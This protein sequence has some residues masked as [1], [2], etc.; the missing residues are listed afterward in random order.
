[1]QSPFTRLKRYRTDKNDQRENHATECLAACLHFSLELREI[2][3]KFLFD[4]MGVQ[5]PPAASLKV[6][7]QQFA[8]Q[9]GIPD[10]VLTDEGRFRIVVEIK[11]GAQLFQDQARKYGRW[12]SEDTEVKQYLFSLEK[13]PRQAFEIAKVSNVPGARRTWHQLYDAFRD[14]ERRLAG[15]TE[16]NL[17]AALCSYLQDEGIVST[18]KPSQILDLGPAVQAKEALSHCFSRVA[19]RLKE[20]EPTFMAEPKTPS[21]QWPR[22]EIGL[23]AW[24]QKFGEGYQGRVW[25]FYEVE[26]V[27]QSKVSRFYFCFFLWNDKF[28][29]DWA[30]VSKKLPTWAKTLVAQDFEISTFLG[31][32]REISE[33]KTLSAIKQPPKTIEVWHKD[34]SRTYIEESKIEQ[35]TAGAL[36]DEMVHRIRGLCDVVSRLK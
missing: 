11:V 24:E 12:L 18:W 20:I 27:W 31:R 34:E 7:T 32:G 25:A 36:V 5:P 35:M 4:G 26:G 30:I 1:M 21:G 15:T 19:E 8:G 2:F 17:I 28:P 9:F 3:L 14:C 6:Q 13:D 33:T 10:L 22:L 23:P 16:G 29:S